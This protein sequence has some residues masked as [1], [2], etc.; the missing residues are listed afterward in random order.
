MTP[1]KE[2]RQERASQKVDELGALIMSEAHEIAEMQ[3]K[4][5]KPAGTVE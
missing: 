4:N 3:R 5:N 2:E 1:T